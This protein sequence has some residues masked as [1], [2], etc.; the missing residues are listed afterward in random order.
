MLCKPIHVERVLGSREDI[1]QRVGVRDD[2]SYRYVVR[3]QFSNYKRGKFPHSQTITAK[4]CYI[5]GKPII[6][7][8]YHYGISTSHWPNNSTLK[9]AIV[10]GLIRTTTMTQYSTSGVNNSSLTNCPTV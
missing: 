10:M 5:E 9:K 6:Y 3:A 8:P 4:T 7:S 1:I 2:S